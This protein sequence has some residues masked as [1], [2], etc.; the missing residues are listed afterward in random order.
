MNELHEFAIALNTFQCLTR[1]SSKAVVNGRDLQDHTYPATFC[2]PTREGLTG[3]GSYFW[4]IW[5][6][7]SCRSFQ[8]AWSIDSLATS[9][10]PLGIGPRSHPT[11]QWAPQNGRKRDAPAW[12]APPMAQIWTSGHRQVSDCW[13]ILSTHWLDST[14]HGTGWCLQLRKTIF[15]TPK[16]LFRSRVLHRCRG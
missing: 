9:F 2:C 7:G 1:S 3:S 11:A 15:Q 13:C 4:N 8:A 12:E 6:P 16:P 14:E 10:F 5:D